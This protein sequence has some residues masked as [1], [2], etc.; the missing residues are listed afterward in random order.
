MVSSTP[1]KIRENRLRRMAQRQG[2][3]VHR[4]RRRDP[5]AIDFGT[6]ALDDLATGRRLLEGLTIDELERE[7]DR[8]RARVYAASP[9]SRRSRP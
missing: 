8:G 7:L 4:S 6:F 3:T 1:D 2:M 5:L 9:P